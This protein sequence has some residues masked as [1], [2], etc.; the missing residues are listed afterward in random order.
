MGAR[1]FLR[2]HRLNNG[3]PV[4]DLEVE[5]GALRGISITPQEVPGMVD[6]L[7]VLAV[8][9]TQAEGVTEVRGAGERGCQ[10]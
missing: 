5:Y 9:A 7:P 8:I 3:E 6:E 2:N 1:L 10:G 4:A